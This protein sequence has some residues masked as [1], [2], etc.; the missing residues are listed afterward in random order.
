M[1]AD[2]FDEKEKARIEKQVEARKETGEEATDRTGG[3][4]EVGTATGKVNFKLS[5]SSGQE[6]SAGNVCSGSMLH[7]CADRYSRFH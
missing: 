5:S 2:D 7:R 1:Y 6:E 4:P 3:K